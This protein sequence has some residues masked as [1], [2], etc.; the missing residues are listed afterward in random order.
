MLILSRKLSERIFVGDNITI[1]V[2]EIDK[3]KIRLGI[4]APENIPIFREELLRFDDPRRQ[5]IEKEPHDHI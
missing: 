3:Y 5:T 1:T 2:V 4:T